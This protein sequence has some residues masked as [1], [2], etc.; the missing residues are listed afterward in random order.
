[1][2]EFKKYYK[3]PLKLDEAPYSTYAWTEDDNMALMFD[4]NI[5]REDA[6]KIIDIINDEREDKLA[7][8]TFEG[9]DFFN[10][11]KYIFCI[12]GWGNL[13][14]TGAN[15][16]PQDRA[17]VIQDNFRDFIYNKLKG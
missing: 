14:G 8:L 2:K 17:E 12:R 3:L 11:E 4:D 1:M 7:I 15:N 13:T 9:V 6:Q 16:L 10:N 5:D